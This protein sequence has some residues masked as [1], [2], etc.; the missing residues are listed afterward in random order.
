MDE[1]DLGLKL[2][3]DKDTLYPGE[4]IT[5]TLTAFAK[6]NQKKVP[7][8]I[9]LTIPGELTIDEVNDQGKC[10]LDRSSNKLTCKVELNPNQEFPIVVKA[11]LPQSYNQNK[12]VD[13][14]GSIK[15][16]FYKDS[17]PSNN[18]VKV[19]TLLA[20]GAITDPYV[21]KQ[22]VDQPGKRRVDAM[23]GDEIDFEILLGRKGRATLTKIGFQ[24][25]LPKGL[26][27]I[28]F[29]VMPKGYR[30]SVSNNFINCS[31]SYLNI[32]DDPLRLV[33]TAKVL[34]AGEWTNYGR[35]CDYNGEDTD[36]SDNNSSVTIVA[37]DGKRV[38]PYVK[39]RILEHNG[40]PAT[41][42]TPE[43]VAGDELLIEVEFGNSSKATE[44]V[45]FNVTI[46]PYWNS[47]LKDY[48]EYEIVDTPRGIDCKITREAG[49]PRIT[50][51]PNKKYRPG[52]YDRIKYK[53]RIT[54]AYKTGTKITIGKA[55]LTFD[56]KYYKDIDKENT[57]S[58]IKATYGSI[59]AYIVK[60]I[61]NE[62]KEQNSKWPTY[63]PGEEITYSVDLGSKKN[64]IVKIAFVDK[65]PNDLEFV[66]F[67][68][69]PGDPKF[70]C[71]YTKG[72]HTIS[73]SLEKGT[74]PEGKYYT[75]TYTLKV[76]EDAKRGTKT[77]TAQLSNG[78]ENYLINDNDTR[79]NISQCTIY[80]EDDPNIV[81]D[82]RD[83]YRPADDKTITTKRVSDDNG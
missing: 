12:R 32:T 18:E 74:I 3:S 22:V 58:T 16:E 13:A 27:F 28:K 70:S 59:G 23:V 30:C 79:D 2:T 81:L 44:A 4:K 77:N 39:Q 76:K 48:L 47:S 68:K 83:W 61:E 9:T 35:I 19:Q 62:R 34:K 69:V 55:D 49:E 33:Y 21:I 56:T 37:S 60:R 46:A 75:I 6:E 17:D 73:C 54:K 10:D 78:S 65:L 82:A 67:N 8:T 52:E 40:K 5:Y 43:V 64:D 7:A 38:D 15:G 25:N 50:C 80:V 14:I 42:Q 31:G 45:E 51:I 72:S 57:S 26:E 71:N 1:Y 63:Y 41:T 53:A 24:D 66:K 36:T 20:G 11:T 29:K